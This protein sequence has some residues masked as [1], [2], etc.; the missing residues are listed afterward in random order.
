MLGSL[1]VSR[2]SLKGHE[3]AMGSPEGVLGSP[4]AALESPGVTG[5]VRGSFGG[6]GRVSGCLEGGLWS[7]QG[8]DLACPH[9]FGSLRVLRVSLGVLRRQIGGAGGSPCASVSPHTPSLPP[10]ETDV[11]D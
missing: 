3:G 5:V 9:V 1:R 8:D 2:E 4:G 6:G 7:P 10:P 11:G